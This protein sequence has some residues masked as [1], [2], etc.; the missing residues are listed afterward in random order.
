MQ[1]H[2]DSLWRP[3]QAVLALGLASLPAAAEPT[4]GLS[5]FGDLKDTTDIQHVDWVNPSAPNGGRLAPIGNGALT[6]FDSFNPYIRSRNL[7]LV[8]AKLPLVDAA[9]RQELEAAT[10]TLDRVPPTSHIRVPQWYN[11]RH[12]VA[13]WGKSGRRAAQPRFARGI[14]NSWWYDAKQAARLTAD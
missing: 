5:A 3:A 7:P 14:V 12:L 13:Y 6:S 2:A 9:S 4:H 11:P 1:P 8:A 10:R